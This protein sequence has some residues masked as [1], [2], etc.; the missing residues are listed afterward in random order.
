MRN[1]PKEPGLAEPLLAEL[2]RTISNISKAGFKSAER[3][4]WRV[5]TPPFADVRPE[6]LGE[7]IG[8]ELAFRHDYR[9]QIYRA[10][11]RG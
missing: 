9:S 11:P 3:T 4:A 6:L 1:S 5:P 10:E 7:A 8:F 2:L